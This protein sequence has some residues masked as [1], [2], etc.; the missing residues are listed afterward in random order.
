M[1]SK[2]AL[3]MRRERIDQTNARDPRSFFV[4]AVL[5]LIISFVA[6]SL[7]GYMFGY[8]TL[9]NGMKDEARLFVKDILFAIA[10]AC[11]VSL[12]FGLL[13]EL[14]ATSDFIVRKLS[15]LIFGDEYLIQSR[16]SL[17]DLKKRIDRVLFGEAELASQHSLYNFMENRL[18]ALYRA[19]VRRN[20]SSEIRCIEQPNDD[21]LLWKRKTSYVYVRNRL[22]TNEAV[23]QS[24]RSMDIPTEW[25]PKDNA[26]DD[27]KGVAFNK[28]VALLNVR[29]GIDEYESTA[30]DR[31]VLI[32]VSKAPSKMPESLP[33]E[34]DFHHG[35]LNYRFGC[36]LPLEMLHDR[37]EVMVE[38]LDDHFMLREPGN[39]LYSSVTSPTEMFS[40]DCYFP[41]GTR[42]EPGRFFW[43][44]L[45]EMREVK[46][47]IG[48]MSVRIPGWL[49][50]G[51]GACVAWFLPE[52]VGSAPSATVQPAPR[53]VVT[54]IVET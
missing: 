41:E 5:L 29:V 30:T 4:Y 38:I 21:R 39:L 33:V 14:R 22:D 52:R 19:S 9:T 8:S 40:L 18:E 34:F 44:A 35:K 27:E 2:D 36:S 17:P 53:Q 31:R 50:Q 54:E 51:E 3:P 48:A 28:I 1:Q 45:Q 49:L 47:E 26:T 37:S 6:L 7:L 42:L 15:D 46:T 23:I 16:Y 25:L 43:R 24:R 32:R 12:I 13:L 20:M 11:I 10:T